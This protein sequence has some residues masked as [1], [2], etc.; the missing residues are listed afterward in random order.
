MMGPISDIM[1]YDVTIGNQN[2]IGYNATF[3]GITFAERV[4]FGLRS[5]SWDEGSDGESQGTTFRGA[6]FLVVGF[7]DDAGVWH[8]KD[9]YL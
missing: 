2:I 6:A 5:T 7:Q 4:G 3:R 1:E 9:E 8:Y